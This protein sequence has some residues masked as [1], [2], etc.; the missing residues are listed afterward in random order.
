M[1]S[2]VTSQVALLGGYAFGGGLVAVIGARPALGVNAGSFLVSAVVL[3]G[4]RGGR[5]RAEGAVTAAESLRRGWAFLRGD[6]VLTS[7]FAFMAVVVAGAIV[8]EALAAAYA[9]QVLHRGPGAAGLLAAAIP[10]GTIAVAALLRHDPQRADPLRPLGRI[11]AISATTAAVILALEPTL[12]GAIAGF[13]AVGAVFGA[14]LPANAVFGTRLR[15]DVRAS[16]FGVVS[17]GVEGAQ[18]LGAL[19]GGL[20]A[21]AAGVRAVGVGALVLVA[22]FGLA[23][24]R[25]DRGT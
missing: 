1:L 7:T 17:A 13:V 15:D 8:V 20:A 2:S 12:G 21:E 14:V 4:V 25:S 22:L 16:A 23:T 11:V 6:P 3:L 19:A 5:N 18:A 10:V 24:W 9:T